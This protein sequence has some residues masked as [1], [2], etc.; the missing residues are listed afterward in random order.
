[1]NR[2]LYFETDFLRLDI[3]KIT[4]DGLS[5][6]GDTYELI[7]VKIEEG[8]ISIDFVKVENF[9]K[10]Y[11]GDEY[12]IDLF[13]EF[14]NWRNGL[15]GCHIKISE[16]WIQYP[17][18]NLDNS[19]MEEFME[20]IYN[21]NIKLK[22]KH[23]IYSMIGIYRIISTILYKIVFGTKVLIEAIIGNNY[24]EI[25]SLSKW[26]A[27]ITPEDL[28]IT[29]LLK[30]CLNCK[31]IA[32]NILE[33][34]KMD[35]NDFL[36]SETFFELIQNYFLKEGINIS[37]FVNKIEKQFHFWDEF[38]DEFFKKY[39]EKCPELLEDKNKKISTD[40]FMNETI[41]RFCFWVK[42][43]NEL[44][45]E[46]LGDYSESLEERCVEKFIIPKIHNIVVEKIK[47][48]LSPFAI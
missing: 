8:S 24:K 34:I 6:H 43:Y 33:T 40:E 35:L 10:N 1:M 26:K 4:F 9:L 31:K 21:N 12:D 32:N 30:K 37:K 13:W 20:Y 17:F 3:N 5:G 47:S 25:Y 42:Y 19:T 46:R 39:S 48:K 18:I 7:N 16:G 22:N 15:R 11:F 36:Q 44:R 38:Y 45:R 41:G 23:N 29:D 27:E 2:K 28:G 14:W